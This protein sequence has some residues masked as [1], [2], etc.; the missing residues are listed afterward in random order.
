MK[1]L[2]IKNIADIQAITQDRFD[3]TFYVKPVIVGKDTD[4][5]AASFVEIP[6]GKHAWSYH[7]HD[8]SEELFYI[9]SGQG[10]LRS[11]HGEKSIKAGDMLCFPTGEKGG[12]LILNTS[13]TEP[14][15]YV[16]FEV[17]ASKTDIV[18]MPDKGKF[19][20]IGNH[21]PDWTAVEM[22]KK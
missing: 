13:E 4:T 14:L 19:L 7:Y 5:C 1:D 16:D 21:L 3:T 6:P 12:H 20:L 18:T 2:I 22:P 15:V 17:K 9:I 11:F 8:Q 10:Q